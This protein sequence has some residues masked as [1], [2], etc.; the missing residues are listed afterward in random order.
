M[1][2]AADGID[3]GLLAFAAGAQPS[4]TPAAAP[5]VV[6]SP[7]AAAPAAPINW[8]QEARELWQIV[9]MLHFRWPSLK[10]I[11]TPETVDRLADAW[12]PVLERHNLDLG[13]LMIYFVAATATLPVLGATYEAAK[14][15]NAK[16]ATEAAA[17]GR[18]PDPAKKDAPAEGPPEPKFAAT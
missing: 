10:A 14:A 6:P 17:K 5:G 1:S 15:D 11:Y 3:A 8:K 2:G 7:D 18:A 16:A 12:A 13:K 4:A 9:A